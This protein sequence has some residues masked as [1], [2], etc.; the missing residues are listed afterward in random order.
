VEGIFR[1]SVANS[2]E[3]MNANYSKRTYAF[4]IVTILM[5]AVLVLTALPSQVVRAASSGFFAPSNYSKSALKNAG[6]GYASDNVYVEG[7]GNNKSAEYGNFGLNI[8]AGAAINQVEVSVEGHG[9]KNW[10]VAVSKNGGTSYSSYTTLNNIGS[11]TD[12]TTITAGAGALWGLTGWSAG[13]FSNANFK[14]KIATS[15]GPSSNVAY[16]DQIMVR[17]TY[18]SASAAATTLV[19]ATPIPGTYGG[20]VNLQATLTSNGAP[21][22][23]KP[24]TFSLDGFFRGSVLTN[25]SGLASLSNV[26]LTTGLSNTILNAG[27]YAVN[28]SFSGDDAY[29]YSS[30]ADTQIV[31]PLGI[32][33][34]AD[35]K[36]RVYGVNDPALTFSYSPSLIGTDAF[37]GG[38]ARS[39]GE[40]VGVYAIQQGTLALNSNYAI[41]Y[42][43]ANLTITPLSITIRADDK[44]I[45]TGNADPEFTHSISE[46]IGSDSLTKLPKCSV[47]VPH[48]TAGTYPIVCSE[49]DAGPN[50]GITYAGGTLT[51]SD[52]IILTV[53]AKPQSGIYGNPD[54]AFDF[55]YDGFAD[56]DQ[57]I[58][59]TAPACSVNVPHIN[60]GSYPSIICS[61][62]LDSKYEF[63]Y[64]SGTLTVTPRPVAVT[65]N[66]Q[67][68]TYGANDPDLTYTFTPA[69]LY[70][71]AFSGYLARPAGENV[72][73]YAIARGSLT[74]GSNYTIS[75]T[76]AS[77]T[78]T[79]AVLTVTADDQNIPYT[80]DDPV[81]TFQYSDFVNGDDASTIDTAPTC[82]V[83]GA[84]SGVGTY[85][86]ACL[87]GMDNNYNF[88]FV[89]GTLS[90]ILLPQDFDDVPSSHPYFAYIEVLYANGYTG[91]CSISPLKFCPDKI[92]D[93][94]QAAVFMMRGANGASYAPHPTTFKFNDNWSKVPYARSWAEAM[95]ETGLTAGCQASPLLYC[96]T[97]Q[98]TREEAMIFALKMKY[99]NNYQ[100]PAAT[101][102]VFADMTNPS[103]WATRWA[104]KAYADGLIQA[105]GQSNGKPK[106][107][108]STLVTRGLG[109][110]MIVRAKNLTMP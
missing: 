34:T 52:K 101:G 105:C 12:A 32:T 42:I 74:L 44:A 14:V 104:E 49:A 13:S 83:A 2:G 17:V 5:V 62:G 58:T 56:G 81:F 60:V 40:D 91:G 110:Y 38:L 77:L 76:A 88:S 54:P 72:G 8:P 65:A 94:A 53:T 59:G 107:C 46:M 100:P 1:R 79:P 103:Y 84:H 68:K 87:G 66:S 11:N 98:L 85:Q 28:A 7:T 51:V 48:T 70:G 3:K 109:A 36:S 99:G 19:V 47:S 75:Y 57:D 39:A 97:K 24:V 29:A 31:N 80:F 90:V 33:V 20:T 6:N 67:T 96:P 22:A 30:D 108:P 41:T 43:G 73:T 21:V 106:I 95:R 63:S 18:T 15:G 78:V 35:A 69:L 45:H 27:K 89:N 86:I 55:Q 37:S 16:L 9:T 10:K 92:L 4:Q 23:G 93:R 82:D 25:A 102:T 71:D 26:T 50:Y 64:V 61:G